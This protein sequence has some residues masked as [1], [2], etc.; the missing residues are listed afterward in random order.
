MVLVLMAYATYLISKLFRKRDPNN[1]YLLELVRACTVQG[2]LT[3]IRF[4][5]YEDGI[6]VDNIS[7][8]DCI[9]SIVE[10]FK[11]TNEFFICDD[12]DRY[13]FV[14][15]DKD[16]NLKTVTSTYNLKDYRIVVPVEDVM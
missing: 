2:D 16:Y 11:E 3:H 4:E 5:T 1:E 12:N 13:T 8:N 10:H 9:R 7:L 14:H 15:L 6:V